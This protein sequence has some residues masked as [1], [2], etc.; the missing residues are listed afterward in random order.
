MSNSVQTI[1]DGS[2][3]Y[4]PGGVMTRQQ[5]TGDYV[6]GLNANAAL[7][8][9]AGWYATA[10]LT[11]DSTANLLTLY[12]GLGC[13]AVEDIAAS[14]KNIW[15]RE[16]WQSAADTP[17]RHNAALSGFSGI[18]PQIRE[19]LPVSGDAS[20]IKCYFQKLGV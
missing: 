11:I 17:R 16:V 18:Q 13:F 9:M 2:N 6:G 8:K 12:P 19:L 7:N 4:F 5:G 1:N 3:T 10:E 14:E 20:T 15:Y